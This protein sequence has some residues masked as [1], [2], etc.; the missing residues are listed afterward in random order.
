MDALRSADE[1]PPWEDVEIFDS[2]R[3]PESLLVKV[4]GHGWMTEREDGWAWRFEYLDRLDALARDAFHGASWGRRAIHDALRN[5][6]RVRLPEGP[7][8]S[9]TC[10]LREPIPQLPA[11]AVEVEQVETILRI[12]WEAIWGGTFSSETRHHVWS[13]Y[14]DR[15]VSFIDAEG[16]PIAREFRMEIDEAFFRSASRYSDAQVGTEHLRADREQMWQQAREASERRLE[17]SRSP[18]ALTGAQR[19]AAIRAREYLVAAV[20]GGRGRRVGGG[21]RTRAPVAPADPYEDPELVAELRRIIE[22]ALGAHLAR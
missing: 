17:P 13:R 3:V 15:W 18:I 6:R 2:M 16:L 7:R 5:D 20:R 11:G 4:K 1:L 8:F 22:R 9:K 14:A 12:C 10:E 19:N 21:T